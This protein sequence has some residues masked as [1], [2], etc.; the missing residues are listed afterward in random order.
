MTHIKRT[1]TRLVEYSDGYLA[2]L[3]CG[4]EYVWGQDRWI[5]FNNVVWC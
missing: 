5:S 4:G 1:N 2:T 3:W